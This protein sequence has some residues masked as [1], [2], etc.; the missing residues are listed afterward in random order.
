VVGWGVGGIEAEAGMLGQPVYFLDPGRGSVNLRGKL[1]SGVTADRSRA[2]HHRD[3][4]QG[5]GGLASFVEFFGEGT[6]SLSSPTAPPSPHGARIRRDDGLLPVD[7]RR[8][9]YFEGTGR[10][11]DEIAAFER[12]SG[13]GD[14]RR[15]PGRPDRLHESMGLDLA[16]VGPSLAGPKRPQDRIE[17]GNVKSSLNL[18]VLEAGRGERLQPAASGCSSVSLRAAMGSSGAGQ[19][20]AIGAT[21]D[22]EEMAA[23]VR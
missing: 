19:G 9:A 12:T 23:T 20:R 7:G 17:I 8:V 10:T 21:R 14:V 2:H 13:A 1:R 16:T 6:A 4:A 18:A 15:G 3:A 11:K 22:L 5:E